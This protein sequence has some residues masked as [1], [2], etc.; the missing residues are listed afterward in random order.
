M[1]QFKD[2]E[3]K[4]P[5]IQEIQEKSKA[6]A[7]LIGEGNSLEVEVQAVKDYFKILDDFDTLENLVAIRNSVDTTDKFYEEEMD[8]FN[9]ISPLFQESH[10]G[11][12]KKLLNSKNK[13]GLIKECG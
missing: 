2:F 9:E 6:L 10:N 3:Y 11:F 8:Y 7:N 1:I 13:A 4:R 12:N 5:N